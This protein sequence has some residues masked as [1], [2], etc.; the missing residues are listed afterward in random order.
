MEKTKNILFASNLS[1]EMK[2]VFQ[3]AATHAV[4]QNANLIV[5]HVLE[6]D[7]QAEKRVKMAFGQHLYDDLKSEHREEARNLLIGKNVEALRIQQ[8]IAGFLDGE[9]PDTDDA[10]L[11]GKILVTDSRS[12]ADGIIATAA[13]ENCDMIVMGYKQQGLMAEAMG[14]KVDHKVLKQ[15]TIPVLLVPLKQ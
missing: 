13:E 1:T 15:A 5:V 12:V 7:P 9:T 10:N 2:A 4:F 11:I 14:D 8:A 6:D 3:H